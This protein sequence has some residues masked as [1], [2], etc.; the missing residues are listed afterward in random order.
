M[1]E[2][3]SNIL[4]LCAFRKKRL[5]RRKELIAALST[6]FPKTLYGPKGDK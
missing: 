2:P 5:E 1:K 3:K 6:N 4:D